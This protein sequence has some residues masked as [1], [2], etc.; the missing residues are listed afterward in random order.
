[1]KVT[2]IDA[3]KEVFKKH[4]DI[5][6]SYNEL[7]KYECLKNF[8]DNWDLSALDL[9]SMYDKSFTSTISGRLW[10]G[11]TNSAKELMLKFI[12]LDKEFVRSM[13]RD[14]YN[15]DKDLGMRINRFKFHCDQLLEQ[16]Q[17]KEK[18]W[19]NHFHDDAEVALYLAFQYPQVYNLFDYAPFAIVM[20]RLEIKDLPEAYQT[21]RYMKL[22]KALYTMI[23]KDEEL[24]EL[25]RKQRNEA[26]YYGEDTM[27]IV[28]DYLRICS[29]APVI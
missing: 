14:L 22:S 29:Q 5:T 6:Q 7:Y 18:Q 27:L 16:L 13:F 1:M 15:E 19:N 21:E 10:G 28:H 24:L 4:L 26:Q 8:T 25:H 23:S 12:E 2:K 9:G 3:Y 11:S 20:Q 17:V